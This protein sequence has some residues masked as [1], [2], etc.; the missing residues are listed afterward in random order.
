MV[1]VQGVHCTWPSGATLAS[2]IS[3]YLAFLSSAG[4]M[5]AHH[6][7][8]RMLESRPGP[9][10]LR[11]DIWSTCQQGRQLGR[12]LMSGVYALLSYLRMY[13]HDPGRNYTA[14]WKYSKIWE[15]KCTTQSHSHSL[16]IMSHEY[17]LLN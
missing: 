17:S 6:S 4:C 3:A 7:A 5:L 10:S 8:P 11:Q 14:H 15:C 2:S 16:I 9:E 13:I 1:L 12:V